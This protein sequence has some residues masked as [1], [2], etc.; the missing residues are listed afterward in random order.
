MG[1][2]SQETLD[3]IRSIRKLQAARRRSPSVAPKPVPMPDPVPYPVAR[4]PLPRWAKAG[5]GL[6]I[7]RETFEESLVDIPDP[8]SEPSAALRY[9]ER[10]GRLAGLGV[11][12]VV[13][14]G[15]NQ[16]LDPHDSTFVGRWLPDIEDVP[17]AM[18]AFN[19]MRQQGDWDA[20]IEAYQDVLNAG[21]GFWG[22]A[23]IGGAFIPTGGPFVAGGKLLSSAP[24]LASTIAKVAPRVIRPGVEAGIRGGL[25]GTGK[26]LRA[27]WQAEEA[28]GRLALKGLGKVAGPVVRPLVSRFRRPGEEA[29]EEVAEEA[30]IVLTPEQVAVA[31]DI[32]GPPPS[33]PPVV[34]DV[35]VAPTAVR[36][37]AGENLIPSIENATTEQVRLFHGSQ[38]VFDAFDLFVWAGD[39]SYSRS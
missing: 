6:P 27:P 18:K 36:G 32:L 8:V 12:T 24:K 3:E 38:A 7:P 14:G 34:P 2:V 39:L 17:E 29:I 37:V 30:P 28:A 35:P 4:Q 16:M 5:R 22:A 20:G 31:D 1:K 13:G 26:V 19:R 21:P 15:L 23:E 9:L 11:G 25:T 10:V 33:A